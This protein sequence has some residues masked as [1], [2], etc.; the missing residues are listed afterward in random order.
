MQLL[1]YDRAQSRFGNPIKIGVSSDDL[2]KEFNAKKGTKIAKK[3]FEV[4]KM[5]TIDDILKYKVIFV[6]ENWSENYEAISA[7]SIE[8]KI[9]FIAR[10]DDALAKGAGISFR[11]V[12]NKPNMA[13]SVKNVRAQGSNF[14]ANFFKVVVTVD[15]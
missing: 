2:L 4:E 5:E 9:L 8:N 10:R 14:P 11:K 1:Q 7:K 3:D 12:A 15:E 6:D 13:V